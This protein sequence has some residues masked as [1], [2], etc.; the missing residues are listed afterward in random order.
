MNPEPSKAVR[1]QRLAR[2]A[3]RRYDGAERTRWMVVVDR[4]DDEVLT[5]YR[6]HGDSCEAAAREA[7]ILCEVLTKRGVSAGGERPP[8]SRFQAHTGRERR[9]AP[10]TGSTNR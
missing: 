6:S 9:F 10:L 8:R 2:R 1:E 3:D 4:D 7:Q 5:E